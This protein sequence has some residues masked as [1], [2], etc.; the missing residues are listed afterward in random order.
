MT[1]NVFWLT[2]IRKR[3]KLSLISIS[4]SEEFESEYFVNGKV[5]INYKEGK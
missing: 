4:L 2:F 3:S 5:I 1:K